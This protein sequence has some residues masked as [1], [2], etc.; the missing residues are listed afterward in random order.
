MSTALGYVAWQ[1]ETRS[2]VLIKRQTLSSA[3]LTLTVVSLSLTGQSAGGDEVKGMPG[4]TVVETACADDHATGYGT[5][6]SHNQKVVS[7]RNGFFTTHIRSRNEPYTAQQWRLS[8]ST[9]SGRSFSTVYE[10]TNATNPP[11]ME[12]DE[13]DNLYLVRPDFL[14]GNAYLYRF[15]ASENYA[16]PHLS[17]IPNGSAGKYC[18]AYDPRRKQLY[19]FAHNNTFHVLSLDGKVQRS[20]NLLQAGQSAVLQYPQ[21]YLEPNGT[22]HAAWTTQ[23]HGI[24]LYWDI[25]YMQSKDGGETWQKMDGTPLTPP[26]IADQNGPTDRLTLDDEFEVHTW[27]SN[28]MAKDGKLHFFYM[29]QTQPPREHYMRYDL[30][31][32][33]RDLDMSPEFKGQSI[34]ALGLDGF[35]ATRA[36]LPNS[37]LY[38]VCNWQGRIACL[39]SDD[40]GETWY[41]Y[42]ASETVFKP[43][44]IGGCR[45]ITSD[46]YI[47]G[48]FTDQQRPTSEPGGGCPVYFIKIRAGLSTAKAANFQYRN[49]KA[50][51]GFTEVRGQPVEVRLGLAKD[52]WGKWQ[53][54]HDKMTIPMKSRPTWF[55]LRS[56]LGVDSEAYALG[57]M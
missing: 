32:A 11:V 22:L 45:E 14:D 49:Q 42:A 5:F 31:A 26:V 24:Y 17:T 56:R 6:Q 35:F 19:Y 30:R 25:R 48:S 2:F 53:P 33:R 28:F 38:C 27:L 37:P 55:Q 57:E 54:Y 9:D 36:S 7:N 29:A 13:Q 21:L 34:A 18:M 40:N 41:D 52:R 43:Y 50:K 51:L 39:A 20:C 12:T 3:V 1:R 10:S 16:Q 8:R 23:K 4:L 15:L 47:I 46:G 44:S